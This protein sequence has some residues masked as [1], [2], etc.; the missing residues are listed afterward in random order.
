MKNDNI[1]LLQKRK[2]CPSCH[3]TRSVPLYSEPLSSHGI[4]SYLEQQYN[5]RASLNFA[6]CTFELVQCPNCSLTYQMYVPTGRL[7][8][9]IYDVWIPNSAR[10][11]LQGFHDIDY[12]RY[13]SEQIQFVI[14]QFGVPPDSIS[15]LD[16]GFGWA[17][18][19]KMAMAYGLDV[20]GLELS[21][22]RQ[23][24][25]QSIGLKLTN[26]QELTRN[27]FHFINT[28][29]V[30]EHIVE[31]HDLL[32]LL[33]D[34]LRTDGVIKISVP[35]SSGSLR[36]LKNTQDF[37]SLSPNEIMPIAPLEHVN[38]FTYTSLVALADSVGLKPL[39]P[40]FCKLYNSSSGWLEIKNAVR[41]AARPFYRHV[42]PKNTFVY[43]IR[44]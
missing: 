37:S 24:Y 9:E 21:Q 12:Y 35:N 4:K 15:V 7:L 30:F 13:Q 18:W 8:S 23:E 2:H 42:F 25:A 40:S 43:F 41:L 19:A 11:E 1:D 31:P 10:E 27:K 28:E 16:F 17:E 33:K 20:T 44:A 5:G 3:S 22:E 29:Q 14:H 34:S 38:C 36:K 32:V 26:T 6:G 39:H